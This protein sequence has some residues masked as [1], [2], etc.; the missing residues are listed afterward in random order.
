MKQGEH[1]ERQTCFICMIGSTRTGL[2]SAGILTEQSC[3]IIKHDSQNHYRILVDRPSKDPQE[4][5]VP[6]N[7][8]DKPRTK[9]Q[10]YHKCS[11][12]KQI[13]VLILQLS[14][15]AACDGKY[16]RPMHGTP[17]VKHVP[18]Q[19]VLSAPTTLSGLQYILIIQYVSRETIGQRSAR[20]SDHIEGYM[21]GHPGLK[22]LVLE[23]SGKWCSCLPEGEQYVELY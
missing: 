11:Q 14:E 6:Y 9:M 16:E 12:C 3:L 20:Y 21:D 13:A 23:E 19:S 15:P 8:A 4:L 1:T 22:F 18:I 17:A 7:E 5:K 2:V 10:K